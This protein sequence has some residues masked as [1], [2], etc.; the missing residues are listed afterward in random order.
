M[1]TTITQGSAQKAI[2]GNINVLYRFGR[3][4]KSC[5]YPN[6]EYYFRRVPTLRKTLLQT[7][8]WLRDREIIFHKHRYMAVI[9]KKTFAEDI[10][11]KHGEVRRTAEQINLLCA[12]GFL[13]KYKQDPKDWDSLLKINQKFL[14][15]SQKKN[16]RIRAINSFYWH[17]YTSQ[18]LERIEGR[19]A[20]LRDA[21]ITSSISNRKL[22][23]AGLEDIA[24]E[25]Y[26]LNHPKSLENAVIEYGQLREL[27]EMLMNVY[28]YATKEMICDNLSFLSKY[29]I[30]RLL[31]TFAGA[32]R[33]DFEYKR[34]TKQQKSDF[35]L[36]D[37]R[38]IFTRKESKE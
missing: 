9:D 24:K 36:K 26:P 12:L 37:Y 34:P 22:Y 7:F 23:F 27:T 2:D 19:A 33:A 10:R 8:H 21:R 25:V 17:K 35:D 5:G 14:E 6:I 30:N 11:K 1:S 15:A 29:Q 3:T 16:P 18:E 20:R 28:G 4:N 31:D 13:N 38:W 32:M